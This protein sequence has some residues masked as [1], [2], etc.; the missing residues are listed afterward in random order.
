MAYHLP[1]P[2]SQVF[3]QGLEEKGADRLRRASL[4]NVRPSIN[5]NPSVMD[6]ISGRKNSSEKSKN[7][8]HYRNIFFLGGIAVLQ[9]IANLGLAAMESD[10][11]I[12]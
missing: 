5:H 9:G 2:R 6:S 11:I 4:K 7:K 12:V 1:P 3:D 8:C 10:L